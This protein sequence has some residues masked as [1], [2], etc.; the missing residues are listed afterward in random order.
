[1]D[2]TALIAEITSQIKEL[3][4]TFP[5]QAALFASDLDMAGNDLLELLIAREEL[6]RVAG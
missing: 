1:M 2:T 3:G 5:E 4:K 6:D